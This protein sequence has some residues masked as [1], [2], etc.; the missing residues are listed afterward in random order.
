MATFFEQDVI[1]RH[2]CPHTVL[3]DNGLEF[4]GDFDRLLH[5][6]GI[7]HHWTAPNHPQ[8]NGLTEQ[9]NA[10]IVGSLNKMVK[11]HPDRWDAKL[12]KFLLG[13]RSSL[14]YS[15]KVSPFFMVYAR[16]PLLP[17]YLSPTIMR[18]GPLIK[19]SNK[20]KKNLRD[21]REEVEESGSPNSESMRDF[22]ARRQDDEDLMNRQVKPKALQGI[23]KAQQ[24]QQRVYQAKRSKTN[25]KATNYKGEEIVEF[26]IGD[27]VTLAPKGRAAKVQAEPEISKV[28]G[29]G[30]DRPETKGKVELSDNSSPPQKWWE[31]VT[32]VGLFMRADEFPHMN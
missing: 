24:K 4:K 26:S 6:Y 2:G 30:G 11:D 1:A 9:H 3:S 15:T 21:P 25:K 29:I 17:V 22:V 20:R 31:P 18:K 10:T 32:N 14:H 8:T 19:S 16:Q 12:P 7:D 23:A 27:M 5:K 28:T 13:Y